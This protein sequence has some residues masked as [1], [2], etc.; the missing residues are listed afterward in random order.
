MGVVDVRPGQ[1]PAASGKESIGV[2]V[3]DP[4]EPIHASEVRGRTVVGRRQVVR[5]TLCS[6]WGLLVAEDDSGG[7]DGPVH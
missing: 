2:C 3:A 1:Q 5:D 7:P 4:L 6:T